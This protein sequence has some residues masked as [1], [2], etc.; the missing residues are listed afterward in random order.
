[1]YTEALE[2]MSK[3]ELTAHYVWNGLN[4]ELF[5]VLEILPQS[6][7]EAAIIMKCKKGKHTPWCVEY[8]GSG[9]YFDNK[10]DM[11]AYISTRKIRK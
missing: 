5:K 6:R 10:D 1:M 8:K 7:N 3:E 4:Q 11:E 9:R 2:T